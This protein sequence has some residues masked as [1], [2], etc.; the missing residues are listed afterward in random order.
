MSNQVIITAPVHS[1]LLET[2]QDKGF[3]LLYEP[4]ITYEALTAIIANAHGI[5]VTTRLKIDAAILEK[6]NQLKWIGRIGSGM[7]LIDTAFAASKNIKCVSSPEGNRTTV[8]EHT[9]GLLLNLMNHIHSAYKEVQAGKWMPIEQMNS[10]EKRWA[11]LDLEI[12]ELHLQNC[13]LG[14]MYKF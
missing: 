3:E 5:I 6:A 4:E 7:E 8:G 13:C 9:L 10:Q 2:L 11:L 12:L 14:L 1:F